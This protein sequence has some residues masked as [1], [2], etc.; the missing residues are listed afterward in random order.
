MDTEQSVNK[1]FKSESDI[2]EQYP[3]KIWTTTTKIQ[4]TIET[5]MTIERMTMQQ[6]KKFC[7]KLHHVFFLWCCHAVTLITS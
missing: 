3:E 2:K 6:L 7:D 4:T 5:M 1:G